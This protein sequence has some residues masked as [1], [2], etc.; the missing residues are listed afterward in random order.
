MT[1]KYRPTYGEYYYT[2]DDTLP[3]HTP[4]ESVV[5]Y[6]WLDLDDDFILLEKGLVFRDRQAAADAAS[7]W[8][9]Q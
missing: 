5:R 1:E 6:K 9:R 8:Q 3:C 7:G 4:G 2:I